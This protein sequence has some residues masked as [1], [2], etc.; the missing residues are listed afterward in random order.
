MPITK[1]SSPRYYAPAR[2]AQ[3]SEDGAIAVA[4]FDC[5]FKRHK[6]SELKQ[7]Q[8]DFSAWSDEA[9]QVLRKQAEV[10]AAAATEV[11]GASVASLRHEVETSQD[12]VNLRLLRRVMTGWR[13]VQGADSAD[14]PFSFEALAEMEEDNPG[15]INACADAFWA[16][17]QPKE[18][19]HLAQKN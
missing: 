1:S 12:S 10:I 18:A 3:L 7:L 13:A 16:S 6:L 17:L 9:L 5:Q 11:P 4:L 2:Y 14:L 15:F 8:A 19:A